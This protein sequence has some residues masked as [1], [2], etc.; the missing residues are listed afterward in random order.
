VAWL[1]AFMYLFG[2]G[3]NFVTA[4][5]AAV[6]VG[7]GIDYAIH[8][9]QR[10]REELGRSDDAYQALGRT[11]QGTGGALIASAATSILGFTIMAFAPM[12][13]FSSYGILTAVMIFLAV[14]ASLLVL[15]SLLLLVTPR[16]GGSK[17]R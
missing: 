1:Y 3:L 14:T 11:A 10:Y 4:T 13:M 2:F 15:P 12:P 7:V 16:Q 6:S 9:T 17:A 5:I 8:M